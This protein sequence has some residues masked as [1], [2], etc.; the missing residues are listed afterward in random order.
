MQRRPLILLL[1]AVAP[2]DA[3]N[4]RSPSRSYPACYRQS[5]I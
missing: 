1:V 4:Q 5:T 3:R 2:R